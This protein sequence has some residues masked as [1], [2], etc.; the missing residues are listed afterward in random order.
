MSGVVASNANE[1]CQHTHFISLTHLTVWRTQLTQLSARPLRI[2]TPPLSARPLL[3]R[4]IDAF[5]RVAAGLDAMLA[6]PIAGT[7]LASL[8]KSRNSQLSVGEARGQA[9][10]EVSRGTERY[11]PLHSESMRSVVDRLVSLCGEG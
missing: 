3:T 7:L 4:R 9:S 2:R 1:S 11:G 6:R 10:G 8:R 5:H